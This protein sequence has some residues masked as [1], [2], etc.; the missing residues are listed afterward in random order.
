MQAATKNWLTVLGI[1]LWLLARQAAASPVGLFPPDSLYPVYLADPLRPTFNAQIQRYGQVGIADT[2]ASRFDLKMGGH[3][4]LYQFE[5]HEQDWQWLLL[6]GY[7]GQF[8]ITQSQD[9]IGWD[10]LYG[11]SLV[12]Q[13]S[14]ELAWRIGIKHI[15]A[16]VGD[17]L[18]Q[19]SGRARLGYTRE[20]FRLGLAWSP[21]PSST[22]YAEAGYAYD[23]RNEALQQA[24]RA[25][26]GAQYQ[27]A[28]VYRQRELHWY[29]ALD[30][31][32]YQE[33]R[34]QLNT[35]VQL[36]L[37][38]NTGYH[39]WRLGLEFYQGR[40]QLGEFFQDRERYAAIGLWFD[41]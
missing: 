7:H 2:G 14:P 21:Q 15:S 18:M 34:W 12:T 30:L 3:L 1:A 28:F 40:S 29:T 16:H 8:D 35:T 23:L 19:R 6:A 36:G 32:G 10:G 9:N 38:V 25:Q 26:V 41:L 31:S 39:A 5:W 22:F 24:W 37:S 11:L 33:N 13:Q 20:E 4:P 17:E 27:Q